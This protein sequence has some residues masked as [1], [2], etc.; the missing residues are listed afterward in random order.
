MPH[1][2]CLP[3]RGAGGF[4]V[5]VL[6]H[7]HVCMLKGDCAEGCCHAI[8]SEPVASSSAGTV[9]GHFRRII[10]TSCNCVLQTFTAAAVGKHPFFLYT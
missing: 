2:Q 3:E 1:A 6:L 8:M 9:T 5:L 10:T 7:A 4:L